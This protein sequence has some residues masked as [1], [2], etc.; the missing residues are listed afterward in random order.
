MIDRSHDTTQTY[1]GKALRSFAVCLD[2]VH[3]DVTSTVIAN[4]RALNYICVE[5]YLVIVFVNAWL[6]PPTT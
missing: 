1:V 6:P 5:P 2:E 4:H 3:Y